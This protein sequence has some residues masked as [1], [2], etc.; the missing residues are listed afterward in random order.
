MKKEFEKVLDE[1]GFGKVIMGRVFYNLLILLLYYILFRYFIIMWPEAYLKH[2]V[3]IKYLPFVGTISLLL[4]IVAN[5]LAMRINKYQMPTKIPRENAQEEL[6]WIKRSKWYTPLSRES[7]LV[8]LCDR[9]KVKKKGG[10]VTASIGD[11]LQLYGL[12]IWVIGIVAI[13]L[14]YMYVSIVN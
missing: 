1:K 4:G 14:N 12:R 8:F 7:R 10:Y 2:I 13:Y 9:Y 11:F 6:R 5:A 3:V